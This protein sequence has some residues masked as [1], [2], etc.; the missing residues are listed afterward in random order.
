MD[1]VRV[2]LQVP[3]CDIGL[4]CSVLEGYEG[5]AIVRTVN[6]GQGLIE[7]LVAPAFHATALDVLKALAQDMALRFIEPEV[8]SPLC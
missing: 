1:V 6:P 3:R 4:L 2:L 8:S 5:I 7:L